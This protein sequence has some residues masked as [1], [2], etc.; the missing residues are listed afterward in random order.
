MFGAM[1]EHQVLGQKFD[2]YQPT[3]PVLDVPD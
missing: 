3:P 2:V 1:S